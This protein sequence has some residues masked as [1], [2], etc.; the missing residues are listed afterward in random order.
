MCDRTTHKTLKERSLGWWK[1]KCAIVAKSI[2]NPKSM[3]SHALKMARSF[4]K[5]KTYDHLNWNVYDRTRGE[6]RSYTIACIGLPSNFA[7][8][9]PHGCLGEKVGWHMLK[10]GGN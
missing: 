1:H 10:K 9:K 4:A 8:E 6:G 3:R 7:K 5:K 2:E